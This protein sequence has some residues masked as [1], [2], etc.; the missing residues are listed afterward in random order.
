MPSASVASDSRKM[1][2]VCTPGGTVLVID[3]APAPDKADAFNRMELVRD[4]SHVRALPLDELRA[5]FIATGLREPQ[6]TGYRLESTLESLLA[7]S[8]PAPGDE[9][10]IRRIFA[11]AAERDDPDIN[12]YRDGNDIRYGYPV[13]VLVA[14]R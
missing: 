4:P 2:R 3:S 5:L 12:A 8:F 6:T 1:R 13:A 7:R 14:E 11:G 9:Q 10:E